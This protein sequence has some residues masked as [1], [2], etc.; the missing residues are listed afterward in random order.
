MKGKDLYKAIG[1]VSEQHVE[2]TL[3]Y[4]RMRKRI[5][6]IK[7]GSV[8]AAICLVVTGTVL[9]AMHGLFGG[10]SSV[11]ID[12]N[13]FLIRDGEL[14]KYTGAETDVVIPETV[15][16]IADN[17]FAEAKDVNSVT[18]TANVKHVGYD[19]FNGEKGFRLL[20]SKD[21][22][23]FTDTGK[24]II[25]ADGTN[26]LQYT[27]G[28]RESFMIP[29]GVKQIGAFAF[30]EAQIEEI[31]FPRGL[32][33]IGK[34]AFAGC[35]L[36]AIHLPDSVEYVGVGAFSE[37]IRA[38]DGTVPQTAEIGEDAFF[39][40]PFYTSMLA[41]HP[42]PGEDIQRGTVKPSEAFVK[43]ANLKKINKAVLEFIQTGRMSGYALERSESALCF[44]DFKE[45]IEIKDAAFTNGAWGDRV[46]CRAKI[47]VR[48]QQYVSIGL[49]C[50]NPY[51]Y[52]GWEDAEWKICRAE[53]YPDMYEVEKDGITL[54][55]FRDAKTL[56]YMLQEIWYAEKKYDVTV[57]WAAYS[58]E[59]CG[60]SLQRITDGLY[61]L[62]WN[63]YENT[64]DQERSYESCSHTLT[65]IDL[66]SG[67]PKLTHYVDEIEGYAFQILPFF[68]IQD[69]GQFM[70]SLTDYNYLYIDWAK[71]LAGE[72]GLTLYE[73]EKIT[74]DDVAD[75]GKLQ[76]KGPIEYIS[77]EREINML[78]AFIT[79]DT[80]ALEEYS[81]V[82]A[83]TYDL[84]KTLEF[85]E[86]TITQILSEPGRYYQGHVNVFLDVEVVKS[87]I[88]EIPVG[89][90]CFV[91]E[92]GPGGDFVV[93][94]D[95]NRHFPDAHADLR[96]LYRFVSLIW[97]RKIPDVH[98]LTEDELDSY[99]EAAIVY[100]IDNKS[101]DY[102]IEFER[103]ITLSK[104]LF[105]LTVTPEDIQNVNMFSYVIEGDRVYV[106]GHG[107]TT[108]GMDVIER[109]D[110]GDTITV[111]IR[112]YAEGSCTIPAR[113]VKYTLTRTTY[114][115]AFFTPSEVIQ[116]YGREIWG[117]AV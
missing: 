116:D 19:A 30:Y 97:D 113:D 14:L 37:C 18:L 29:Y 45:K 81:Y 41:G 50:K 70:L 117:Y 23:Y 83:G 22:Q 80:A 12:E 75:I 90:H 31:T 20:L 2:D 94:K 85:G 96:E 21:N 67:E 8:A 15:D 6:F 111:T 55:F 102:G 88:P 110:W 100:I 92:S 5:K 43:S 112:F 82:P 38:V 86:Y 24:C 1:T 91:A 71:Y 115:L 61:V 109:Q 101:T 99:K 32:E 33:Y 35:S 107:G 78:Q 36:R 63:T 57:D 26:L 106:G 34:G 64:F 40:V 54:A 73:F 66:R 72:D 44:P 52:A 114:G 10:S 62:M 79:K 28:E 56:N 108:I 60:Y 105:G 4:F 84:Y 3:Q 74:I 51:D 13:G 87:D 104:K 49:V 7:M 98:A 39:R 25:S 59:I 77:Y 65:A 76:T 103:V 16:A 93:D 58:P 46:E 11:V 9:A 17:A 47:Y 48:D 95:R 42:C 53:F 27:G 69:D 89:K 68:G